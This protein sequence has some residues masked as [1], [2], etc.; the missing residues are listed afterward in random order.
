MC[1]LL[2]LSFNRTIRPDFSIRAFRHR[3]D[4]NPHG[5]GLAYYPDEAVQVIKEPVM[6]GKSLMADFIKGQ[7]QSNTIIGHVRVSSK[8]RRTYKNTHPFQREMGGKDYVF[9]HNG[10]LR[11]ID[12]LPTG[13]FTPVGETDSER[14]FCH[15]LHRIEE[16]HIDSWS[17]DMFPWLQEVLKEINSHGSYNCLFSDG[18]YLFAYFDASAYKGLSYVERKTPYDEIRLVDE[19]FAI[20]LQAEKDP[21]QRGFIFATRPMT[22]ESWQSLSPGELMVCKEGKVLYSHRNPGI[23]RRLDVL[24]LLRDHPHRLSLQEI[25]AEVGGSKEEIRSTIESLLTEGLIKQDGRD[26]VSWCS[27]NATYYTVRNKRPEIDTIL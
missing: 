12:R 22:D 16:K 4:D 20:D 19:D 5:W 6:A 25:Y 15:L 17:Q 14:A 11:N 18:E 8:G 13:R 21:R 3:G 23:D 9:A 24:R 7:I 27:D 26:R 1:E 10:T 2:A